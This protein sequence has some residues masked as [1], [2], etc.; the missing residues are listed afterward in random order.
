[1]I[2]AE[3]SAAIER[4][5]RDELIDNA[6]FLAE[7]LHYNASSDE[8]AELL[9]RCYLRQRQFG[10]VHGL[11]RHTRTPTGRYLLAV[12]LFELQLHVDAELALCGPTAAEP[13]GGAAGF[14]LLGRL[15][16]VRD[17]T[18]AAIDAFQ[19]A[20]QRD[21]SLWLA[22]EQLCELG[23]FDV[24][25]AS[26]FV[27]VDDELA[28]ERQQADASEH[29]A[30]AGLPPPK[31]AKSAPHFD[32]TPRTAVPRAG[33]LPGSLFAGTP[34]V[35]P[36][37]ALDFGGHETPA[38]ADVT[39][40]MRGAVGGGGVL[41]GGVQA[42]ETPSPTLSN[43]PPAQTVKTRGNS[44]RGISTGVVGGTVRRSLISSAVNAGSAPGTEAPPMRLTFG[45]TPDDA[46]PNV[47]AKPVLPARVAQRQSSLPFAHLC[48]LLTSLGT[49]YRS[50]CQFRCRDALQ[51][52]QQLPRTPWTLRMQGRAHF[53]LLEYEL[54]V[55][56]FEAM[57][58]AA[59][60]L[61]AGVEYYSTTLWHLKRA[62]ELAE[63]AQSTAALDK[64]S[65]QTWCAVGNCFSLA[66]EHGAA[67]R[68]FRRAAQVDRFF[69]YAHTLAGHEAVANDDSEAAL[70][71]YRQAL[72]VDARHYNAWYGIGTVYYREEKFEMAEFHF[73]RAL[74]INRNSSVLHSYAGMAAQARGRLNDARAYL[75]RAVALAPSNTMARFK[76]ASVTASLGRIDEAI[77]QLEELRDTLPR[78]APV[79]YLLGQL[80][81]HQGRLASAVS[82]LRVA[83]D[84]APRHSTYIRT[85]LEKLEARL[86]SDI[87]AKRGAAKD[88]DDE[89]EA[90][91]GS[92]MVEVG[93][94][95]DA[96]LAL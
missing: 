15:L 42:Y 4:S 58:R 61:T 33:V 80:H 31:L 65:P 94:G 92:S 46:T 53:E 22:Y 72:R 34:T 63:L 66:R 86:V 95:L 41:T 8:H 88:G 10:R 36:A 87:A 57:R 96:L 43:E 13:V 2:V 40:A 59:A 30:H 48:E 11:L 5:L 55:E 75:D 37:A 32:G 19:Q 12:A 68:F 14:Y 89:P 77:Q 50:L 21:A 76:R 69:A 49:V 67:L 79:Y 74:L 84:L 52:L 54:A 78:E 90:E 39:P 83:L 17:A 82:M 93:D 91:F 45:Q 23:A 20:L 81:A 70:N 64:M 16:R 26:V 18:A 7:Q 6:V 73:R 28:P 47:F 1:M 60:H 29:D 38:A 44:Q 71:H 85:S 62:P 56:A 25:P 9:A 35:N 51:Q 27:A 3:L 24:L